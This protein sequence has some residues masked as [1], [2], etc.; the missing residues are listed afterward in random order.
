M[1]LPHRSLVAT[2]VSS[3]RSNKSTLR[4]KFRKIEKEAISS[5]KTPSNWELIYEDTTLR[6]LIYLHQYLHDNIFANQNLFPFY[7]TLAID[8]HLLLCFLAFIFETFIFFSL[9]GLTIIYRSMAGLQ[10]RTARSIVP[11][12]QHADKQSLEAWLLC[13]YPAAD[14]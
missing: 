11:I 2:K 14:L 5:Q 13:R 12:H 8:I 4:Q 9:F 3:R 10:G 1:P 6:L 7:E